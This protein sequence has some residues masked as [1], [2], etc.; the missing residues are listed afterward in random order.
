MPRGR[1]RLYLTEEEKTMANRAKS[2]RSYR[3][4][5]DPLNIRKPVRFHR[6][7]AERS[8]VIPGSVQAGLPEGVD[9]NDLTGWMELAKATH[10]DYENFKNGAVRRFVDRLCIKYLNGQ[11]RSHTIFED[12]LIEIGGFLSVIGRCHARVLRLA[13]AGDNLEAVE[14]IQREVRECEEALEHALAFAMLGRAEFTEMREK[15]QLL[16]QSYND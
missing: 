1:P 13:G 14:C 11:R 12:A 16:H 8:G 2:T 15:G 6:D 3:K 7:K 9:P 4:R 5:K 10:K